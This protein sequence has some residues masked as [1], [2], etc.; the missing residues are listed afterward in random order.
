MW[1]GSVHKNELVI[2]LPTNLKNL[3]D[4]A[5]IVN[6]DISISENV[7]ICQSLMMLLLNL[8]GDT[9]EIFVNFTIFVLYSSLT[10]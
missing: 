2:C 4:I 10:E 9:G 8:T 6:N 1:T 3:A 7:G 5:D